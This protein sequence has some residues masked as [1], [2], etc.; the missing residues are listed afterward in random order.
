VRKYIGSQSEFTER[1][2]FEPRN[3]PVFKLLRIIELQFGKIYGE[4]PV[5]ENARFS[6]A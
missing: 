1:Q 6:G 2:G 3:N 5:S 4:F